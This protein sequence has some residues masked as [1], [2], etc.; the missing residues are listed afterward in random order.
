MN[1]TNS[2]FIDERSQSFTSLNIKDDL[3]L[4]DDSSD[5]MERVDNLIEQLPKNPSILAKKNRMSTV[6]GLN[7]DQSYT[8]VVKFDTNVKQQAEIDAKCNRKLILESFNHFIHL[9]QS[10]L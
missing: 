8:N 2:H 1:P 7:Y 4:S 6:N 3:P 5:V 9:I 10:Q